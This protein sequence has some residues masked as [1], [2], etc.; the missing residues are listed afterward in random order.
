[1][2]GQSPEFGSEGLLRGLSEKISFAEVPEK[3]MDLQ[4][5]YKK[6]ETN[7]K[8]AGAVIIELPDFR[9]LTNLFGEIARFR[10]DGSLLSAVELQARQLSYSTF[11]P[12]SPKAWHLHGLRDNQWDCWAIVPYEGLTMRVGLW[13]VRRDSPT[14]DQRLSIDFTDQ[15]RLL[16]IPPGVAHG[17]TA[18]DRPGL[19]FYLTTKYFDKG[20]PDEGRLPWDILG[21]DFWSKR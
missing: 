16:L 13:D 8:I 15:T 7:P 2:S 4:G 18:F 14:A 5:T 17:V 11:P 20:H 12:D 3:W 19:L 9:T 21:K 1:M 10:A 6:V